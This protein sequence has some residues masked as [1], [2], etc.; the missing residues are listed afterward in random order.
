VAWKEFQIGDEIEM[1]LMRRDRYS[2]FA[3]PVDTY[4]PDVNAKHPN[5]AQR[6]TYSQ[7]VILKLFFV[8]FFSKLLIVSNVLF[9]SLFNSIENNIK[10]AFPQVE[11]R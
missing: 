7:L 3:L 2:L 4:F 9:Q 6:A 8:L 5:I 11:K 10:D 1:H